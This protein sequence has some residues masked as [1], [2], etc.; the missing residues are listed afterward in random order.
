MGERA[1]RGV[2]ELQI[3]AVVGEELAVL[4]D[5]AVLGLGQDVDEVVFGK[6]GEDGDDRKAAD[7]LGD[8]AVLDQVL[9]LGAEPVR[10]GFA[11]GRRGVPGDEAE[12]LL[13]G[14]P[15]HDRVEADEGAAADEEDVLRVDLDVALLRVLAAAGGRDVRHGALENLEQRLLD[16]LAGDV[17]RDG[18]VV[19]AAADLVDLVDEDDPVPG[20]L[21][22]HAGRLDEVEQDVLDILADVARLGERRGVGDGEGHVEDAREGPRDE[23]LA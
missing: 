3:H 20:L 13:E 14:A 2:L 7:E 12:V 10:D 1:Q 16:A 18:D 11:D 22:V 19:G 23:R 4:A 5:E 6:L 9:G 17:A 21:D 15:A 8:E